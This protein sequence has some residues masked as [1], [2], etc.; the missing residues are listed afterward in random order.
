MKFILNLIDFLGYPFQVLNRKLPNPIVICDEVFKINEIF[1][2][3][4]FKISLRIMDKEERNKFENFCVS[5]TFTISI[6]CAMNNNNAHT[7]AE[8]AEM[9]K[10]K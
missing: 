5:L 4:N 6:L 1:A 10:L 8:Q 2:S 3:E 7:K 9:V